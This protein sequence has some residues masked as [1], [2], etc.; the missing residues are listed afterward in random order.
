ML[1][2]ETV[3]DNERQTLRSC[4]FQTYTI[5]HIHNKHKAAVKA[6]GA[7]VF[8]AKKTGEFECLASSSTLRGLFKKL[9]LATQEQTL[10]TNTN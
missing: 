2:W 7:D 10:F 1:S 6:I 4:T 8:K 9:K 5:H 3:F